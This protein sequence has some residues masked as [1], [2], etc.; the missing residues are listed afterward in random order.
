MAAVGVRVSSPTFVGRRYELD[1]LTR[2]LAAARDGQPAMV[3]VAGEAGVGKTRFVSEFAAHA[4]AAGAMVLEGGCV[5]V[6]AEGLPY[7]PLIEALRALGHG[8][9]A[10]GLRTGRRAG[11]RR[12]LR[13]H[14]A[15][16]TSGR[17]AIAHRR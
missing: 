8:P 17:S 6:G 4:R 10:V 12:P 7:A 5:P 11:P 9:V 2:A 1:R 14:A 13:A 3:L 15:P 16:R